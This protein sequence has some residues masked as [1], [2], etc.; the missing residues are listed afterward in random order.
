MSK[1]TF[2]LAPGA[3][4]PPTAFN[5]LIEKL[6]D[7]TCHTVAF[8]SIQQATTVQ[9]LQ[10]DIDTV[11]TL[12]QSE[13]DVGHDVIVVV[14]SW[15]GLPVC[16]ALDGLSKAER[17]EAGKQGGVVKLVFIAAFI[18][19][20]GESLIGAF[21][22]VPPPWYVRDVSCFRLSMDIDPRN[23]CLNSPQDENGTVTASDPFWLFFHDVPD[24]QE[25]AATLRPHAW[26]TKNTPATAAA[27]YQIPSSYL[28]CEEDRAIPM[29]VQQL[30]VDRAQTRG[31]KIE[32]EK[33]ATSHSPWLVHPE[34]VAGYLRRQA[35]ESA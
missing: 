29:A 30:M 14:H 16:S 10:P 34:K 5:P 26:V 23:T 12:V 19:Q 1:P 28:L 9:D 24:G 8:P 4:Y 27:Y 33:I 6:S 35:G 17:E 25:W 21:G 2:I 31:A 18:P 20:L 15:A 32:T 22:G 7:Y 11:R 13:A 3:W